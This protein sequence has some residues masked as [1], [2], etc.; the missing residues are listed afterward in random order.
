M[1]KLCGRDE[2]F[3]IDARGLGGVFVKDDVESV[4]EKIGI[5]FRE[6]EGRAEF[7]DVV[8]GAV[9]A[10]EDAAFAQAVDDVVGF[11]GCC[12]AGVAIANQIDAEK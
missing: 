6:N 12:D 4:D 9:S 5:G 10:G 11:S 3:W 2:A 1:R 8:A 7:D